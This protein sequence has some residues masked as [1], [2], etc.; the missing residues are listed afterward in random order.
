MYT[1]SM[2]AHTLVIGTRGS[3]LALIQTNLV[4]DALKTND[5]SLQVEARVIQTKG[6]VNQAPIPLDTIGKN[7]FTAEIEQ[8]LLKNEIDIAVHSLKDM[9]PEIPEGLI[10]LPVLKR[11]DAR[12]AFISKTGKKLMDLP[13]GAIVGTDSLRRKAQ[14]LHVRPDFTVTSVRGNVDTRLRKLRE[15]NYDAIVIA[16]AGLQRLGLS[17]V[18]T[19]ILDPEIFVPSPGQGVLAAQIRA[20]DQTLTS[21]IDSIKDEATA[22]VVSAETAFT[23][24]IGGG[25]KLPVGCL[26]TIEGENVSIRGMMGETDGSRVEYLSVRGE[27]KDAAMLAGKLAEDLARQF[28]NSP[29]SK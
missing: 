29:R 12:E 5:P 23:H 3:K 26:A 20:S 11:A 9:A 27:K 16:V 14:L 13:Q 6:D 19:E 22:V 24:T 18:I 8:A 1:T 21:M 28:K 15:E 17:D 25:C 2:D 7:W 4:A 10:V